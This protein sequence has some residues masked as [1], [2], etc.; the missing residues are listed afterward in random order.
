MAQRTSI[1]ERLSATGGGAPIMANEWSCSLAGT[2]TGTVKVQMLD[3]E[4]N[5]WVDIPDSSV[6][7]KTDYPK[8]GN[9]GATREIRVHFTRTTGN[10]D[11]TLRAGD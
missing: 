1:K 4:A 8:A 9:N 11:Y 10:L 6:T 5:E 7:A 2:W 3:N